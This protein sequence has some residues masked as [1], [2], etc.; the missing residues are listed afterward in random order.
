MG[1]A[2]SMWTRIFVL[3]YVAGKPERES[4]LRGTKYAGK[5]NIKIDL[6]KEN[7]KTCT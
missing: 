5:D 3:T 7:E 2:H 6:K 1:D 4:P